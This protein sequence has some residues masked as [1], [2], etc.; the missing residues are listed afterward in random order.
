[1]FGFWKTEEERIE[2]HNRCLHCKYLDYNRKK[3]TI[4]YNCQGSGDFQ[5]VTCGSF[6]S[7]DPEEAATVK[8]LEQKSW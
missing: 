2:A 7:G 1:M 5:I 3:C 4:R 6:K 8:H